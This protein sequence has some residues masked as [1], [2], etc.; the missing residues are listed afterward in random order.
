MRVGGAVKL[1]QPVGSDKNKPL[2]DKESYEILIP[3][4][5]FRYSQCHKKYLLAACLNL[6]LSRKQWG[7]VL[8]RKVSQRGASEYV[9]LP[10]VSEI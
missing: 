3:M 1:L 8:V 6:T 5:D 9:L 2:S 10:S 7:G 4:S